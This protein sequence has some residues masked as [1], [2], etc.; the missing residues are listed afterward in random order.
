MATIHCCCCRHCHTISCQ[1]TASL[2]CSSYYYPTSSVNCHQVTAPLPPRRIKRTRP[3]TSR[4]I[5]TSIAGGR[6]C[7]VIAVHRHH[8]SK[9][10]LLSSPLAVSFTRHFNVPPLSLSARPASDVTGHPPPPLHTCH[11]AS[12]SAKVTRIRCSPSD[13]C[14]RAVLPLCALP[15]LAI[16]GRE[17]RG[18]TLTMFRLRSKFRL[19]FFPFLL[20]TGVP[21]L[22]HRHR[23]S[24]SQSLQKYVTPSITLRIPLIEL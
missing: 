5:N 13:F 20:T 3:R 11:A 12:H 16:G 10:R 18:G 15:L 23:N 8:G 19:C 22:S 14:R 21:P 7:S 1:S 9:G 4:I 2:L 24:Y 17:E 6:R